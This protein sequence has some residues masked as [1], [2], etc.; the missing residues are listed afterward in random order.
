MVALLEVGI[1]KVDRKV[2]E[3]VVVG[4][5]PCNLIPQ[6]YTLRYLTYETPFRVAAR[7]RAH[8]N[9]LETSNL[10]TRICLSYLFWQMG[11]IITVKTI[12]VCICTR[13]WKVK[14]YLTR[15]KYGWRAYQ[16]QSEWM[17]SFRLKSVRYRQSWCGSITLINRTKINTHNKSMTPAAWTM[18][19]KP[20][21]M[22]TI[23]RK[24]RMKTKSA[25]VM[26]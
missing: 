6:L 22:R 18:S 23:V 16:V 17:K 7:S 13:N 10:R 19:K 14:A 2:L 21:N 1:A 5:K 25:M 24:C 20:M 4:S 8:C 11:S 15:Y 26:K 12:V 9:N 3:V